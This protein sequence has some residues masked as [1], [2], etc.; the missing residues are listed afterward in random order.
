MK[1]KKLIKNRARPVDILI[2]MIKY[3]PTIK[4][5]M[6]SADENEMDR[7]YQE[8]KGVYSY[9]KILENLARGIIAGKTSSL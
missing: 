6:S 4:S 9:M 2:G 3:M 8:Y 1:V 7:Y 5:I